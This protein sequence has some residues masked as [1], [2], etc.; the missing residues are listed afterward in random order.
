MCVVYVCVWYLCV[1]VRVC[2]VHVCGTCVCIV[3]RVHARAWYVCVRVWCVC[4]HMCVVHVCAWRLEESLSHSFP[5][6]TWVLE[7]ELRLTGLGS[8]ALY[9]VSRLTSLAQSLLN[10]LLGFLVISS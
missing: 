5:S 9:P 8:N 1:Y 2:V 3:V 4:M 7:I 10:K 6:T